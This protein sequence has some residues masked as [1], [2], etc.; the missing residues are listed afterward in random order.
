MVHNLL[1]GRTR[2]LIVTIFITLLVAVVAGYYIS[3]QSVA[4]LAGASGIA[5]TSCGQF[6]ATYEH[7]E[8]E[9]DHMH[10]FNAYGLDERQTHP[11]VT[12]DYRN[13]LLDELPGLTTRG[14]VERYRTVTPSVIA[15]L[16]YTLYRVCR[17]NYEKPFAAVVDTVINDRPGLQAADTYLEGSDAE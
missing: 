4:P 3:R 8:S 6:A 12:S 11:Y 5:A 14:T 7:N 13:W 2:G 1:R 9:P 15:G 17:T 16:L 10:D